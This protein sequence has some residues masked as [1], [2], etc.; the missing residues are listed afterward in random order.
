MKFDSYIRFIDEDFYKDNNDYVSA[1]NGGLEPTSLWITDDTYSAELSSALANTKSNQETTTVTIGN[2]STDVVVAGSGE[3]QHNFQKWSFS[4][5]EIKEVK[6][7]I[8]ENG[9]AKYKNSN[10]L[11]EFIEK[12]KDCL[13]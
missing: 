4:S 1:E 7:Y 12:F 11:T 5:D 9:W 13:Q 6:S 10:A 3:Y 8:E 2:L